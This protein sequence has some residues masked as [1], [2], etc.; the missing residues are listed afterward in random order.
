MCKCFHIT[1]I[2]FH[3]IFSVWTLH[4]HKHKVSEPGWLPPLSIQADA[5]KCCS[6]KHN[7]RTLRAFAIN[8]LHFHLT[9]QD[10]CFCLLPDRLVFTCDRRTANARFQH[11]HMLQAPPCKTHTETEAASWLKNETVNNSIMQTLYSQHSIHFTWCICSGVG[12]IAFSSS[13]TIYGWQTV[14]CVYRC[15]SLPKC[16]CLICIFEHDVWIETFLCPSASS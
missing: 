10:E 11:F 5:P 4:V 14:L 16:L 2:L 3:I 12:L 8:A 6:D 13:S 1:A 9:S 15:R 7:R